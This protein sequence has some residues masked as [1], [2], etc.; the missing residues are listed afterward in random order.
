[1]AKNPYEGLRKQVLTL[2]PA[3]VGLTPTPEH[4]RVFGGLMEMGMRGGTASLVVI[5]DGTTSMYYSTGGGI[6]GAGFH[7]AVK[8]PS[9]VFLAVLEK[10]VDQFAPDASE[11]LPAEG[12]VQLRAL[13]FDR[14]RLM[15]A[16]PN[17]DFGEKRNPFWPAFFAG[18][19]VIGAL[20]QLPNVQ[21]AA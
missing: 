11:A 13:T 17:K 7:D 18:H 3:S 20:R 10:L 6:I 5:A 21:S 16:A 1:M 4:Q 2:D 19:A 12:I 14:G 8:G 9:R 15:V